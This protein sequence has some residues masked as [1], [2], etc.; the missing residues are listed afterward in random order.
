MHANMKPHSPFL[1]QQLSVMILSPPSNVTTEDGPRNAALKAEGGSIQASFSSSPSSFNFPLA[2]ASLI[3]FDNSHAIRASGIDMNYKADGTVCS[4]EASEIEYESA[5]GGKAVCANLLMTARPIR[6][7]KCSIKT[8]HIPNTLELKSPISPEVSVEGTVLVVRCN[9]RVDIVTYG[10][11]SSSNPGSNDDSSWPLAPCGI[12]SIFQEISITKDADGSMMSVKRLELY[13]FPT[14]EQTQVA[15]KCAEFRN[16]LAC[17]SKVEMSC[18]LPANEAKTVYDLKLSVDKGEVKG[19]KSSKDWSNGF[20]PRPREETEAATK[21]ENSSSSTVMKLPYAN[22]ASL[23]VRA[24]FRFH[25]NTF[26]DLSSSLRQHFMIFLA[27]D[28]LESNRNW[29]QGHFFHNQTLSWQ[30]KNNTK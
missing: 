4:V 14:N 17:M 1:I 20:R 12:D 3:L 11:S 28:H 23:K 15:I 10:S 8:L 2:S 13:A 7:L 22:I 24:M 30:C 27:T 16:H 21:Q 26:S 5:K 18:S 9:K 25:M 29:R 6:S 19:G